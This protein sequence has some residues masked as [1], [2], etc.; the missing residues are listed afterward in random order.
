MVCAL[1][2]TPTMCP[3]SRG[4]TYL[5]WK[6]SRGRRE[7]RMAPSGSHQKWPQ[8]DVQLSRVRGRGI[9]GT[10]HHPQ[11]CE[12]T[13]WLACDHSQLS[14]AETQKIGEMRLEGSLGEILVAVIGQVMYGDKINAENWLAISSTVRGT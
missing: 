9:W 8:V 7:L 10:G 5:A 12:T 11:E 13:H 2:E 6:N 3:K 4:L 1:Q 14:H